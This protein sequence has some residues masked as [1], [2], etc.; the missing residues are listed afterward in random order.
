[1]TLSLQF[2][3]ISLI[4]SLIHLDVLVFGEFMI[5]RPIVVGPIIGFLL[6]APEYGVLIGLIFELFYLSFVAVGVDIPPDSTSST[7]FAVVC[8]KFASRCLPI[9]IVFGLLVGVLYKYMDI[10]TRFFNSIILSWIDTSKNEFLISRINLSIIYGLV[11]TYFKT[12]LFYLL[13][14]PLLNYIVLRL[15][16]L[17]GNNNLFLD[18]LKI[19]Y[20][21]PS[22][23]IGIG[24]NFFISRDR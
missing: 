11:I 19:V 12:L 13:S 17:A 15:C 22:I 6:G 7:V 4:A 21:L 8:Y 24:L 23:V 18:E 1:M 10:H 2:I 9:S 20:I 5:H 14:F 3:I 16:E